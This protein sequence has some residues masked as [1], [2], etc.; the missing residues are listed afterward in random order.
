M[1]MYQWLF[2]EN[3]G[4]IDPRSLTWGH[5]D[6]GVTKTRL[7]NPLEV[8]KHLSSSNYRWHFK[9]FLY[10][11]M[12]IQKTLGEEPKLDPVTSGKKMFKSF[13][14]KNLFKIK[15]FQGRNNI[16]TWDIFLTILIVI[17]YSMWHIKYLSS[18]HC[19]FPKFFPWRI[20]WSSGSGLIMGNIFQTIL[21]QVY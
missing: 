3:K 19:N 4:A 21:I 10:K 12:L 2:P 16:D 20:K 11:Y 5:N 9:Y 7:K 8:I 13:S 18:G 15:W 17:Y 6:S 1:Y 14:Y